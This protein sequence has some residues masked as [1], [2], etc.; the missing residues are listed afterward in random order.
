MNFCKNILIVWGTKL[1]LVD[2]G[3]I[4][5]PLMFESSKTEGRFSSCKLASL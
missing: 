4:F 2:N 5:V 3:R 1:R